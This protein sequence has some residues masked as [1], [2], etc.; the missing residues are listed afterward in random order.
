[1]IKRCTK[2][3]LCR[4]AVFWHVN[5]ISG[6]IGKFRVLEPFEKY[7]F[8]GMRGMLIQEIKGDPMNLVFV[9][10]HIRYVDKTIIIAFTTE[11]RARAYARVV[12]GRNAMRPPVLPYDVEC[13]SLDSRFN[14]MEVFGVSTVE[15]DSITLYNGK[16]SNLAG[17]L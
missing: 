6:S 13:N 1:M 8:L 11:R 15:R 5:E 4:G 7:V 2:G 16:H 10:P 3:Q 17:G 9:R 12:K 14:D